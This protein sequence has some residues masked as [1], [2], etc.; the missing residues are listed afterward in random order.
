MGAKRVSLVVALVAIVAAAVGYRAYRRARAQRPVLVSWVALE[1]AEAE[2]RRL[3]R[4][5]FYDFSADWCTPCRAM[6]REVFADPESAAFI[7]E[8]F[9]PAQVLSREDQDDG[10]L[11]GLAAEL[12]AKYGIEGY[13]SLV[14]VSA[15]ERPARYDGFGSRAR[16]MAF[17]RAHAK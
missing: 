6:E 4:P 14:V 1:R 15:G 9:V 8:H 2:A 5:I 11:T 10:S 12:A 16:V 17:L 3:G 13:P 7:N